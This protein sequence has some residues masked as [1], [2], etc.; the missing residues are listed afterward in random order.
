MTADHAASGRSIVLVGLM[1]TGKTTTGRLLGERLGVPYVDT[2]DLILARTGRT[3]RDIFRED[4]EAAFRVLET[5][6]LVEALAAPTPVVLAAAGGVVLSEANRRTLR[7]ADALVAWLRADPA[8]LVRRVQGQE[9]RPLLDEDPAGTLATMDRDREPLYRE[10][11][12]VVI[13]VDDLTPV[14]VA[15]RVLAA[16]GARP[17]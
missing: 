2:D 4:G 14:E 7:D 16:A 3:V 17:S 5:G 1:G 8:L 12:D 10:V 15:D 9:H 6:V 13:D 11:A